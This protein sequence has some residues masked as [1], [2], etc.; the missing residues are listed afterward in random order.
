MSNGIISLIL[1]C[2]QFLLAFMTAIC[3]AIRKRRI[4]QRKRNIMEG[5]E[6]GG[7]VTSLDL[8]AV[9]HDSAIELWTYLNWFDC[10]LVDHFLLL[11]MILP[12]GYS[13][14]PQDFI[15]SESETETLPEHTNTHYFFFPSSY[16]GKLKNTNLKGL[17][18]WK[19][20]LLV[21]ASNYLKCEWTWTS[22]L[23][24]LFH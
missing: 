14:P 19:S 9:L 15:L 20:F 1:T 24:L 5:L 13:F 16:R 7:K 8:L 17:K 21:K 12:E 4:I 23:M 6:G 18:Q 22:V 11:W 3:N 2:P 10:Y